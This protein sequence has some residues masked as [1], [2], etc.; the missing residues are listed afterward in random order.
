MGWH[1][2]TQC[3][4]DDWVCFVEPR[5]CNNCIPDLEEQIEKETK[6]FFERHLNADL[7][8]GVAVK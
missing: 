8:G 6:E 5:G 1:K 4:S 3:G 7:V 2:C